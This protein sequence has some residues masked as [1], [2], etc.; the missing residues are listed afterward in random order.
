M[1]PVEALSPILAGTVLEGSGPEPR[2]RAYPLYL[3]RTEKLGIWDDRGLAAR[4]E[5]PASSKESE[6]A[7]RIQELPL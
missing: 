1:W 6:A 7:N 2:G 3:A 5:K 4:E